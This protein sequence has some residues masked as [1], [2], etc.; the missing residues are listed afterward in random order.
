MENHSIK[1]GNIFVEGMLINGGEI[2]WGVGGGVEIKIVDKRSFQKKKIKR[3]ISFNQNFG[4]IFWTASQN[5]L[6]ALAALQPLRLEAC[7][8]WVSA[9]ALLVCFL[10]NIAKLSPNPS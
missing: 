9:P 5:Q 1:G 2:Y 3:G 6:M 7:S 8:Q 10:L 4:T